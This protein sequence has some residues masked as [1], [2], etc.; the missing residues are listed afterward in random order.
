M[1]HRNKL[2][3]QHNE[4]THMGLKIAEFWDMVLCSL[5]EKT[6]VAEVHT[7]SIIK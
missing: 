1:G 5:V 6:D 2:D 4:G 3:A 7:A